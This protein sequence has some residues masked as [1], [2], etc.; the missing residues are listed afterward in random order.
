MAD[1]IPD[2]DPSGDQPTGDGLSRRKRGPGRPV[3][4][5]EEQR[6]HPVTCR[7]TDAEL[8]RVNAARGGETAGAYIRLAA[9]KRPPRVVPA[10]NA[11]AW[12]E[13]ARLS[14]NLN[15]VVKHLNI[16]GQFQ[17]AAYVA[18]VSDKVAELRRLLLGMPALSDGDDDGES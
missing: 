10:I 14:A 11:Q 5:P 4:P 2:E 7:L 1:I 16:T 6:K 18:D 9:L 13:L 15:Q 8:A 3:L 17:G 12:E